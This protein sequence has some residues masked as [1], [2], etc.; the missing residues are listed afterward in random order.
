[1]SLL[2]DAWSDEPAT[3]RGL[4]VGRRVLVAEDD[5]EMRE[6]LAL[7]LRKRGYQVATVSTGA[8]LGSLLGEASPESRFDLVVTDVHMPGSTGLDVIDRLRQNGDTTPV[9]IVTAFP[10]EETQ[11]RARGL[12]VRLLAKPFDLETLR[13][14]V[15]WAIRANAPHDRRSDS[16]PH[17]TWTSK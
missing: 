7:A 11:Q 9:V 5:A 13:S 17:D 15:D 14:A 12:E 8:E 10:R 3:W 1:M 6:I 4:P 16:S 2:E